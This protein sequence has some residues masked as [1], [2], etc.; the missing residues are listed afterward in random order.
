MAASTR[1][2]YDQ[3]KCGGKAAILRV[4]TDDAG[5][6]DLLL[7]NAFSLAGNT[8]TVD[9]QRVAIS[10]IWLSQNSVSTANVQWNATAPETAIFVV[11][12]RQWNFDEIGF[13]GPIENNAGTGVD[14]DI[15]LTTSGPH[16]TIIEVRKMAGYT[17]GYPDNG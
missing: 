7:V 4:N 6:T 3:T 9:T 16:T 2:L 5:D 13:P 8:G 17:G 12:S 1:I 15:I 14:G 10:K 11:G